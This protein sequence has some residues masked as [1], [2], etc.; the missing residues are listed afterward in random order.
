MTTIAW[1][2]KV[3]VTDMQTCIDDTKVVV[4]KL[5]AL[6]QGGLAALLGIIEHSLAILEW[7]KNPKSTPA[8]YPIEHC[9]D[10]AGS[11]VVITPEKHIVYY[12]NKSP[13][14]MKLTTSTVLG[15]G[16]GGGIAM[17]AMLAG[18]TAEEAV[19][20]AMQADANSGLGYSIG[21]PKSGRI[22]NV[23]F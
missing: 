20:I 3:I 18:K 4:Q 2:G 22:K 11:L 9:D 1:D 17:G 10:D 6:P 8:D 5:Y 12:Q 16:T 23:V 19:R 14:P 21:Y 7:V 13:W 15:F